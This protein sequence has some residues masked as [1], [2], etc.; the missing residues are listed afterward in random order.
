ML[1]DSKPRSS[2]WLSKFLIAYQI[3]RS[4]IIH[5]IMM[6][7]FGYSSTCIFPESCSK[8]ALR[9]S[10]EHA[11]I[12]AIRLILARLLRCHGWHRKRL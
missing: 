5:P 1:N 8:Y 11:T 4:A 2:N 7:V 12:P 6:T 3:V 10:R 9:M